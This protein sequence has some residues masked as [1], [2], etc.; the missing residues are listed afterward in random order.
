MLAISTDGRHETPAQRS[1]RNWADIVQELRVTQTGTQIISGFLLTLP[2][3]QRF[4]SLGGAELAFYGILVALAAVSTL[5]GLTVVSFHRAE[6]HHQR[7]PALVRDG[8]RLLVVTVWIVA[9]L[10]VGVIAF[11][12]LVVFGPVTAILAA[13]LAA[14]LVIALIVLLPERLV[15]ARSDREA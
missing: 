14:I 6:F 7:K 12:F 1:D 4:S 10:T 15:R 11:V 3:Q 5:L 2:F 9:L 13:A 8:H